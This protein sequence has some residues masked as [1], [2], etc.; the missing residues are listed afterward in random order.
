MVSKVFESAS[1]VSTVIMS[2]ECKGLAKNAV[3]AA[4]AGTSV[5]AN[6][7]D[8]YIKMK[9]RGAEIVKTSPIKSNPAPKWSKLEIILPLEPSPSGVGTGVGSKSSTLSNVSGIQQLSNEEEIVLEVEVWDSDLISGGALLGKLVLTFEQVRVMFTGAGAGAGVGGVNQG[10]SAWLALGAGAGFFTGTGVQPG[11]ILL[12]GFTVSAAELTPALMQAELGAASKLLDAM[13]GWGAVAGGGGGR[14]V[15]AEEGKSDVVSI[16]GP[17]FYDCEVNIAAARDVSALESNSVPALCAVVFFNGG[18]VGRTGVAE[19]GG[20][21]NWD[22]ESF[23]F[24]APGTGGDVHSLLLEDSVLMIQL[25]DMRDSGG[26][27]MQGEYVCCVLC[28]VCCVLG[29]CSVYTH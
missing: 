3:A 9:W 23:A 17:L 12:R 20:A 15:S 7:L 14:P 8:P 13:D 18:E 10:E 28:A 2:I 16:N 1:L 19:P 26:K 22:S 27:G 6:N 4:T 11:K 21:P 25:W 5:G 24:R 29:V